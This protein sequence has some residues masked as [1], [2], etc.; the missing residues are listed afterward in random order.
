MC[1]GNLHT[2]GLAAL[3]F[4]WPSMQGILWSCRA[5]ALNDIVDPRIAATRYLCLTV[6]IWSV[7]TIIRF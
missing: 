6:K 2:N 4:L 5:D 1:M 7:S 3:D